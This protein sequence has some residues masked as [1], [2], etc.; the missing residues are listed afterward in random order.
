MRSPRLTKILFD[1][2]FTSYHAQNEYRLT[3]EEPYPLIKGD[4]IHGNP[5]PDGNYQLYCEMTIE[6]GEKVLTMHLLNQD[7]DD[8]KEPL[9]FNIWT[10]LNGLYLSMNAMDL[11]NDRSI[12]SA[13]RALKEAT[14]NKSLDY[15]DI[16]YAAELQKNAI[17][18]ALENWFNPPEK[19]KPNEGWIEN[20]CQ[21][22]MVGASDFLFAREQRPQ[23]NGPGTKLH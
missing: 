23:N 16:E 22:I 14:G 5:L 12:Q 4:D 1:E 18:I 15:E 2:N 17:S 8:V 7:G 9:T 13:A 21:Q 20:L 19:G 11:I 3:L 6:N 10:N